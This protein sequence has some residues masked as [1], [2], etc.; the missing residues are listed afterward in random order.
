MEKFSTFLQLTCPSFRLKQCERTQNYQNC[1]KF[2][3]AWGEFKS[4]KT[5]QRD[6]NS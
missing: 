2:E 6:P 5:F 4:R 1:P 3:V